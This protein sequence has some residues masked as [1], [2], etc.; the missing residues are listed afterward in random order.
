V[1]SGCIA[2]CMAM[3]VWSYQKLVCLAGEE[4]KGKKREAMM[5]ASACSRRELMA[6]ES[7]QDRTG[8]ES[9]RVT[10]ESWTSE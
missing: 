2:R 7:S 8:C 9:K 1:L 6:T 10:A 3:Y 5:S 4:K